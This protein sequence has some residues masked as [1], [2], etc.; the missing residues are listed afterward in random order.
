VGGWLLNDSLANHSGKS[1]GPEY[2]MTGKY[3][4]PASFPQ[5]VCV[6]IR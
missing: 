1:A 3:A 2:R 5:D 6:D 4:N